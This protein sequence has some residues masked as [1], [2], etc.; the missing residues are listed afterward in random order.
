VTGGGVEGGG[1]V[2]GCGRCR[3]GSGGWR[4]GRVEEGM[5]SLVTKSGARPYILGA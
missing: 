2:E 1:R 5:I 4:G 3:V